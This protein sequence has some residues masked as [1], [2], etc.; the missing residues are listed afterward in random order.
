MQS[1]RCPIKG[2]VFQN[3]L[4]NWIKRIELIFASA[5]CIVLRRKSEKR[6]ASTTELQERVDIH[7]AK[8]IDQ[9]AR[10]TDLEDLFSAFW[11]GFDGL[12]NQQTD[13]LLARLKSRR[14]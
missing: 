7:D 14:K 10:V 2:P 13:I 11:K 4:E 9:E 5:R 3:L 1:N 12:K 6:K 8:W